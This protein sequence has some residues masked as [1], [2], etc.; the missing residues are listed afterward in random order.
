VDDI[1]DLGAAG[2]VVGQALV[3]FG[4]GVAGGEDFG[5]KVGGARK[6]SPGVG[7]ETE[8]LQPGFGN[9]G[10][11][12]RAAIAVGHPKAHTGAKDGAQAMSAI[13]TR[14]GEV[15][16]FANPL[17]L[18]VVFWAHN[19]FA[20]D[21]LMKVT[22]VGQRRQLRLGPGSCGF[23]HDRAHEKIVGVGLGTVN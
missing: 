8:M 15:E 10:H 17:V 9:K 14:E 20:L 18:E 1:D 7:F 2:E 6:E 11:V 12:G 19:Q 5:G 13:E 23:I 4:A 22:I 3:H 21:H 16:P